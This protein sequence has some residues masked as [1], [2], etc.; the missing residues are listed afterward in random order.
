MAEAGLQ[1]GLRIVDRDQRRSLARHVRPAVVVDV[2]VHVDQARHH[3]GLTEIDDLDAGRDSDLDS[4]PTS[5]M[6]S[7]FTIT[8]CFVSI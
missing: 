2:R 7:P 5:V 4:G 6:R 8:T 1:V 3:R